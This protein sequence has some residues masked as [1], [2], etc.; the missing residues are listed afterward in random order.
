MVSARSRAFRLRRRAWVCEEVCFSARVARSLVNSDNWR[1]IRYMNSG[2]SAAGREPSDLVCAAGF[3]LAFSLSMIGGAGACGGR[4]LIDD[5]ASGG[6]TSAPSAGAAA[7]SPEGCPSHSTY[8]S[9][10]GRCLVSSRSCPASTAGGPSMAGGPS[11]SVPDASVPDA[12]MPDASMPD[13][14]MP[15]ASMPD[16]SMP[17]ASMPDASPPLRS[18]PRR[19][20]CGERVCDANALC[21]LSRP[22]ESNQSP[23]LTSCSRSFC[24]MRREC[25][26]SAD[27]ASGE[28]CCYSVVSSPPSVIGSYCTLPV[29]CGA[30]TESWIACGK[31]EDCSAAGVSQ[32]LA[33][34]CAGTTVQACGEIPRAACRRT[35]G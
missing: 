28:V 33:Q 11:A 34:K 9:T 27:C 20:G 23:T 32:C 14:S 18:T 1:N 26:E 25:D 31:E 15:D 35:G 24:S 21:C 13:A 3:A 5:P 8:C 22:D 17:D 4:V 10:L 30:D 7:T 2:V 29:N 6:F 19:V 12:S 16:A